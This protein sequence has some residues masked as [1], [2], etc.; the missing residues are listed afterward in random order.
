MVYLMF[1]EKAYLSL[2]GPVE[3]VYQSKI[4]IAMNWIVTKAATG[5]VL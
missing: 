4:S 2:K 1:I 5:G 3:I